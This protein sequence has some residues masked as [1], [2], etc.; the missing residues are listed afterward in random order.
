MAEI[1][2][3]SGGGAGLTYSPAGQ[4]PN[5]W[6]GQWGD[7]DWTMTDHST[8]RRVP[9]T[10]DNISDGDPA[11]AY[12]LVTEDYESTDQNGQPATLTNSRLRIEEAGF[13]ALVFEARWSYNVFGTSTL[14]GRPAYGSNVCDLVGSALIG[15]DEPYLQPRFSFRLTLTP[16]QV[17]PT[18]HQA[19]VRQS[20]LV[21]MNA[22]TYIG[23]EHF[24]NMKQADNNSCAD[25]LELTNL[26]IFK[27]AQ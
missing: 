21:P 13:Y 14:V 6:M 26:D 8:T 25:W 24:L 3:A 11:V 9:I 1:F 23:V 19:I 17:G 10:V 7:S 5:L 18:S 22:G 16:V 27:L 20:F 4:E 2:G 15:G 12:T